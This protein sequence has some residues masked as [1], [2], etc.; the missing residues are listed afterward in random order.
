MSDNKEL[1]HFLEK[2]KT[3]FHAIHEIKQI[4]DTNNYVEL[5]EQDRWDLKKGGKYYTTRNGSAIIAFQ[6]GEQI[7]DLHFQV[8]AAHSDSPTWKVKEHA[9]LK[10]GPYVQL[11][12]EGY[13]GMLIAPWFDR[14]LSLAGRVLVKEGNK[15]VS[16]LVDIDRDLLIIPN[17][18][19]HLNR[20]A[21]NG[22][23]YNNQIDLMP[24]LAMD[25]KDDAMYLKMIAQAAG[26]KV[27]DVVSHDMYLYNRT[28]PTTFGYDN[29]FIAS[30][31]IDNLQSA[32]TT[33]Q[34]FIAGKNDQAINVYSVFDNEEVGSATRMGAGG[35]LLYDVLQRVV[36]NLGYT[37]EDYYQ[38]VAKSFML[39]V[40]NGHA[41]HPNHPEFSDK[42]N[43]PVL[44]GGVVI[45]YN[46][47]QKYTT[48]GLSAA[49]F[50]SL[51]KENNIPY[52]PYANR[53]DM[54]GGSTLG[55]ISS[56]NVGMLAVDLGLAQL[57]MHSSYE[58]AGAKDPQ[59]MIDA[60]K[61][62]FST[63]MIVSDEGVQVG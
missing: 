59:H 17:V 47:N 42:N 18:A 40:D 28:K 37:S 45:K 15:V 25:N 11:N 10:A 16:K 26:V 29:E 46:A 23:K 32:F 38:A 5:K 12:T 52:Q 51:C 35:T 21:N 56:T 4:L 58:S 27:E 57:A 55:S 14:P 31:K 30:G 7:D 39:S 53:S 36:T 44:N 61:A 20:E 41:I 49:A 34:G 13:G 1:L 8:S 60:C 9:Q 50:M 6:V 54:P 3:Q 22:Y 2:S 62:F 48:D 33:L 43:H 24:L 63:N 19:I